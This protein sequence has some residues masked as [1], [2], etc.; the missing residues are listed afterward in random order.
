MKNRWFS[1][2]SDY[3]PPL[4]TLARIGFGLLVISMPLFA[5]HGGS[6]EYLREYVGLI[7]HLVMFFFI[8]KLPIP[9]W[10]RTCGNLWIC[11]DVLSGIL[12]ILHFYNIGSAGDKAAINLCLAIRLAAHCFEGLWLMSSALT[13]KHRAI[14]ICG[15]LAGLLL[16]GYSLISPF[17][18]GWLLMLNSPFMLVWF[19]LII[20]VKY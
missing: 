16:A 4:E 19:Y 8:Q 3:L 9:Q 1:L 18:P 6:G 5:F 20:K 7:W 17:A 10:G 2:E 11:L 13:T 15:L 14:Q 12:Y